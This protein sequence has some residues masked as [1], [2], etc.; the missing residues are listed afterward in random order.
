MER[1]KDDNTLDER[2]EEDL[3]ITHNLKSIFIHHSTTIV[4]VMPHAK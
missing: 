2:K 4:L 3:S 1:I